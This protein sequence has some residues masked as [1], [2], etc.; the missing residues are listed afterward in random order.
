[1]FSFRNLKIALGVMALTISTTTH[2]ATTD[3][4]SARGISLVLVVL[5]LYFVPAM[6]AVLRKHNNKLS[7]GLLNLFLGWT[8][9]GWI[10]AL[11]WACTSNRK[12]A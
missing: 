9:L 3:A 8:F 7:I 11:I 1:M 12:T 10:G 4:Q 2:A 6:L 5:G